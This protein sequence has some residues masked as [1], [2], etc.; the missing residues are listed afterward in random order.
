[1]PHANNAIGSNRFPRHAATSIVQKLQVSVFISQS[2]AKPFI[3][4][5]QQIITNQLLDLENISVS[6]ARKTEDGWWGGPATRLATVM[7]CRGVRAVNIIFRVR[8]RKTMPIEPILKY[9][10]ELRQYTHIYTHK[11]PTV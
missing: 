1:M 3:V 7:L 8:A 4:Q 11:P 2:S 10:P 5:K 6:E 9:E